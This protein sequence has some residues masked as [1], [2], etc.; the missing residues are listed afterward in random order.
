MWSLVGASRDDAG[1]IATQNG[2]LRAYARADNNRYSPAGQL[3]NALLLEPPPGE[4]GDD[5]S[6]QRYIPQRICTLHALPISASAR[7]L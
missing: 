6:L 4:R 1:S 3:E 5:R 2:A 7:T